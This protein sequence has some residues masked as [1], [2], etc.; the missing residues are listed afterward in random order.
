MIVEL[1]T[2]KKTRMSKPNSKLTIIRFDTYFFCLDISVIDITLML[3]GYWGFLGGKN[4]I[5]VQNGD[6]SF[7]KKN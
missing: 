7:K 6:Y 4:I 3:F 2:G 1:E 5:R